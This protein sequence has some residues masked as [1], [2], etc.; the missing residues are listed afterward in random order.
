MWRDA[1]LTHFPELREQKYRNTNT[2]LKKIIEKILN[3][4]KTPLDK[5]CSLFK[6]NKTPYQ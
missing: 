1:D 2:N 4:K 3:L 5:K 6:K